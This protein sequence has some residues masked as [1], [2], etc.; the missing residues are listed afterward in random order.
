MAA[1]PAVGV[2]DALRYHEASQRF[3]KGDDLPSQVFLI[4]DHRGLRPSWSSFLNWLDEF[5]PVKAV[6]ITKVAH[7]L[8]S[9]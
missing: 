9:R 3:A 5:L 1:I 8:K 4:Y 6:R 7:W 2:P